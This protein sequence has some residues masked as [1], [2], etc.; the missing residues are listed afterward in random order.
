MCCPITT[1]QFVPQQLP[2]L[3]HH[4][5]ADLGLPWQPG[6]GIAPKPAWA[7]S[8]QCGSGEWP[9]L[10]GDRR[11]G[12]GKNT[13]ILNKST[14]THPGPS[15][16]AKH[17]MHGTYGGLSPGLG[18]P[19]ADHCAHTQP[20]LLLHH[21]WG[22]DISANYQWPQAFPTFPQGVLQCSH[23]VDE[24]TEAPGSARPRVLLMLAHYSEPTPRN[25]RRE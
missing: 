5:S 1:L 22:G 23:P 20:K 19:S 9:Q 2:A 24:E 6:V 11:Q 3:P 14:P 13:L 18:K 4:R 25:S 17:R 21:Q 12:S 16:S 10:S 15:S 8:L 7:G